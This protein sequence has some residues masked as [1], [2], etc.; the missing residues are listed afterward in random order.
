MKNG[1]N[2]LLTT[3][4]IVCVILLISCATAPSFA[5]AGVKITPQINLHVVGNPKKLKVKTLPLP[6]C[7]PATPANHRNGCVV[8]NKTD[9]A[10]I[11]YVLQT[12]PNWH[13]EKIQICN[14]ATKA[15]MVCTFATWQT[16]E[17]YATD[18]AGSVKLWPNTSGVID[19]TTLPGNQTEFIL[20]DYNS[21]PLDYFY[22]ITVCD[23]SSPVVCIDTD[24]PLTNGGR[25]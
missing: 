23:S 4:F 25:R 8:V 2:L 17:F 19:L 11:K 24:P 1:H 20:N 14:G 5:V 10:E 3:V 6:G 22:T 18:A 12:S 15:G 21:V 13:F 16:Y 7:N 9:T